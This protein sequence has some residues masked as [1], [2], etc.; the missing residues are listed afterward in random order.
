MTNHLLRI[1]H[2]EIHDLINVLEKRY[3]HVNICLNEPRYLFVTAPDPGSATRS[4]AG[5]SD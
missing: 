5:G 3:L 1:A 4:V 2:L